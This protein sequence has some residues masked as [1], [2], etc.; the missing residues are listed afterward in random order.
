MRSIA[1]TAALLAALCTAHVARAG[2]DD[3]YNRPGGYVGLGASRSVNFFDGAIGDAYHGLPGA[4]SSS[5]SDSW[6]LN[7]RGGYRFNKFIGTELEYEWMDRF[8]LRSGGF[9]L[10]RLSTQAATLNLKI[11][12]PYGAWQPYGL[13]G[14]GAVWTTLASTTPGISPDLTSPSFA[15]RF[16]LGLDYYMTK[17]L[18]LN[19]GGEFLFDTTAITAPSVLSGAGKGRG[20]DY[21]S[22]QFGFGYRF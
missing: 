7:F 9:S 20:L 10:G 12:A 14:A 21:F 18:Y 8:R 22:G 4:P 16:A 13:V 6:G 19:L 3:P 15:A 2:D 11:V 1:L 17:N 5:A